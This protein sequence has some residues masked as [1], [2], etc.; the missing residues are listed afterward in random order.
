MNM[1]NVGEKFI[2]GMAAGG[3]LSLS[4][5]L[6]SVAYAAFNYVTPMAQSSV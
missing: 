3:G 4:V 5:L 2:G 6:V 1:K